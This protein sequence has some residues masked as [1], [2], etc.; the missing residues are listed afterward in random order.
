[1]CV[2]Y[3][4][5]CNP[6]SN[7]ECYKLALHGTCWHEVIINHLYS[8]P[9]LLRVWSRDQRPCN[10]GADRPV[11]G[12]TV[13]ECSYQFNNLGS[14]PLH[15]YNPQQELQRQ[16]YTDRCMQ[17]TVYIYLILVWVMNKLLYITIMYSV[18]DN[19]LSKGYIPPHAIC[20]TPC[21]HHQE[22]SVTN[23]FPS[24]LQRQKPTQTI[25]CWVHKLEMPSSVLAHPRPSHPSPSCSWLHAFS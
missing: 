11:L 18:W 20:T 15:I 12:Y 24:H 16:S 10:G 2:T 1:M 17:S 5:N 21:Y 7:Q 8:R 13:A 19:T 25:T 22:P 4:C 14:V 3:C 23:P 6:S 9:V